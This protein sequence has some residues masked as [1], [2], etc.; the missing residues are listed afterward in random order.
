MQIVLAGALIV[1]AYL[2]GAVPVGW[3]VCRVGFGVNIFDHGSGRAGATNVL[4]TVGGGAAGI[5]LLGDV[6]KG[7]VPALAARVVLGDLQLVPIL[8]A[9]AAA[10]GHNWSLFTRM[11][12]GRGVATSAG[13]VAALAPLTV[14][15]GLLIGVTVVAVFRYVSLGSLMGALGSL[16]SGIVLYALGWGVTGFHVSLIAIFTLF[17]V[18]QHIDNVQ[19]LFA[20]KERRLAP[21]PELIGN[22]GPGDQN[23]N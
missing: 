7:L 19:R 22:R 14:L 16:V 13:S 11:R 17:L 20:G 10:A 5:V 1:G 2:F 23:S 21:W 18:S 3:L 12:G 15:I 6:L 8:A 4:R 9:L